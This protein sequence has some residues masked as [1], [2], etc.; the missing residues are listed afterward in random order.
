[1]KTWIRRTLIGAIGMAALGAAGLAL[2]AWL[3]ERK[4]ARHVD[5]AIV[6]I[7]LPTDAASIERGHYLFAT[8]GCTECH[9]PDG[10]GKVFIDGDGMYA[11]APNISPGAGSVVTRYQVADWVRT[12]RHGVKPDGQPLFIMPS[13]DYS[14][15]TDADLGALVA[16]LRQMPPV[17]G[18]RDGIQDSA[19][20][21]DA[22]CRRRD[23]GRRRE[24]RSQPAAAAARARRRDGR[25]WR[26]C[27][28]HVRR[29]PRRHTCRAAR[30]PERRRHGR[31]PPTSRQ[32]PAA[33][34]RTTAASTNS[35]PCCAAASGR[36]A[37]P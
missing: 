18:K 27:G 7:A 33:P 17:Q 9:G 20:G 3:G 10:A 16:Y 13:E 25:A 19:A 26:L 37:A 34:W 6:P 15:L 32:A 8:R 4:A 35:A 14:R 21:Q 31:L 30:S 23:P 12:I 36:T 1:M 22:V 2:G 24:D 5:V 28:Q 29:L 11:K